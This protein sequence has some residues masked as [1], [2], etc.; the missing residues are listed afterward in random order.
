MEIGEIRRENLRSY[1]KNNGGPSAVAAALGY[2]N[3]SFLVQMAGPSP[4][5]EVT[6]KSAREFEKKLSLPIY[7][8]DTPPVGAPVATRPSAQPFNEDAFIAEMRMV[9]DAATNNKVELTVPKFMLLLA[10]S[11]AKTGHVDKKEL[12]DFID[13]LK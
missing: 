3:A 8:F 13:M 2:S 11:M 5:R 9:Y 6:E 1:I 10:K 7:Y 4:V 12:N